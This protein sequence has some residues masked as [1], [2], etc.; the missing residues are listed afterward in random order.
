MGLAIIMIA[1]G[2]TVEMACSKAW[3]PIQAASEKGHIQIAKLLIDAN[4]N[5]NAK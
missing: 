2:A 4:V 1:A 5:I 3:T